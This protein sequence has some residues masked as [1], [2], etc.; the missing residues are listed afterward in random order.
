VL[1]SLTLVEGVV[2][3]VPE[4]GNKGNF[5]AVIRFDRAD[6][7]SAVTKEENH[8]VRGMRPRC[9]ATLLLHPDLLVREIAEQDLLVLGRLA[10]DY[11]MKQRTK[12][13]VDLR[14]EIDRVWRQIEAEGR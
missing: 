14:R 3:V 5:K 2:E 6:K 8:V 13:N 1:G 7:F 10:K 11:M 4:A 12:A 9:Q